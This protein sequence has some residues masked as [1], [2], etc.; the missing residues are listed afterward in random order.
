[1]KESRLRSLLKAVSWRLLGTVATVLVA[2]VLTRK[3]ILSLSIGLFE[4]ML[5]IGL[6]YLHERFWGIIPLG[7]R[8]AV[9]SVRKE[10][11][12]GE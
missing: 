10:L 7:I 3:F 2:F 5:K 1:M 12:H 8:Q 6:F 4:F 9:P 11:N